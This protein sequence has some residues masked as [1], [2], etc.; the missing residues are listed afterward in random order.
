M[1]RE[2]FV[3]KYGGIYEHSPWVAERESPLALF[4]PDGTVEMAEHLTAAYRADIEN[5]LDGRQPVTTDG[6]RVEAVDIDPGVIFEDA[7]VRVTAFAVPHTGW[8]E[9]Y[10]YRFDTADRSIVISGDTAPTE[11]IVEVCDGCD[12]L[13]HEVYSATTFRGSRRQNRCV[14]THLEQPAPMRQFIAC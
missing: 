9:A 1:N 5:R 7:R 6:W 8:P 2:E 4:G 3:N 12:V 11:A 10:G 14:G 13:V